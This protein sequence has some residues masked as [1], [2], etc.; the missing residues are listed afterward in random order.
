MNYS[1]VIPLYN[2]A[3]HIERALKSVVDQ[4]CQDFEIIV[5]NDG[6]TDNGQ[7]I[8]E[9]I[10]DARIRLINQS[11]QGVSVARNIGIEAATNKYVAFLDAD[12]EW[13]PDF[14]QNIQTLINNYSDCGAYAAAVQTIRPDGQ[15]FFP[16]LGNLPPEPW[17]GIL[18]NFFELFQQGLS[19]FHPSS[20]VIPKQ[21]LKDVGGFPEG[22]ILMEDIACWVK[23]AIRYPIAFNPKRLVIYHQDASNRSNIHKNLGEA[24]FIHIIQEAIGDDLISREL[25]NEALE[26]VAQWQILTAISNVMIGNPVYARQFLAASGQTRKYKKMWLW[27]RFWAFLPAGWPGKILLLKQKVLG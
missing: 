26:F 13:L 8:V 4:T 21:V 7:E 22:V 6:S 15:V 12:D 3:L 10:Q 20:I 2:K 18:P 11:N 17:I 24:P 5:V 27:W 1:V 23:I 9:S 25:Q 14:L 19:A 16:S